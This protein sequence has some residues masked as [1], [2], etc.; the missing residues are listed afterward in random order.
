VIAYRGTLDSIYVSMMLGGFVMQHQPTPHMMH[1]NGI[2]AVPFDDFVLIGT[3]A[4]IDSFTD[5]GAEKRRE[6][7]AP[8]KI[9][10]SARLESTWVDPKKFKPPAG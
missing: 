4:Q 8:I 10:Q 9:G 1:P 5:L 7:L 3:T 6:L 2:Y